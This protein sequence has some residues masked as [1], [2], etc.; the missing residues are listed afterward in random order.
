MPVMRILTLV[1]SVLSVASF[2]S[3]QPVTKKIDL[4]EVIRSGNVEHHVN[5]KMDFHDDPK[6][7]WRVF[8]KYM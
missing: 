1:L 8:I 7:I 4:L 2:L 6:D 5:P 3:A